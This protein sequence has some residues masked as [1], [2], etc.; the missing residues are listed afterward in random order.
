MTDSGIQSSYDRPR[1]TIDRTGPLFVEMLRQIQEEGQEKSFIN[2]SI[3]GEALTFSIGAFEGPHLPGLPE[4]YTEIT[5]RRAK[6]MRPDSH[7]QILSTLEQQ[8]WTLPHHEDVDCCF[9][10]Q[11]WVGV[12]THVDRTYVVEQLLSLAR[13]VFTIP[14]TRTIEFELHLVRQSKAV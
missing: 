12:T 11:N 3:L 10:Y 9:P 8:G 14:A 2:A 5:G 1:A 6:Q 4:L 13:E 7:A